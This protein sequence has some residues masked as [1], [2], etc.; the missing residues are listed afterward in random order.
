MTANVFISYRRMDSPAYAGWLYDVLADEIGASHVFRDVDAIEPGLDFHE[1]LQANV[2]KCDVFLAIIGPK[3]LAGEGGGAARLFDENDFV[4]VEIEA[5]LK[6]NIRVIP[7]LVDGAVMPS[8]KDLPDSLRPLARR[9]AVSVSHARFRTDSSVILRA[10]SKIAS[11]KQEKTAAE[12]IDR[13]RSKQEGLGALKSKVANSELF[14]SYIHM[15]FPGLLALGIVAHVSL[16]SVVKFDWMY[17]ALLPLAYLY[18][19]YIG[20]K[21][22]KAEYGAFEISLYFL[23]LCFFVSYTMAGIFET[24]KL[25]LVRCNDTGFLACFLHS[26]GQGFAFGSL[27]SAAA[28]IS[29]IGIF[30]KKLKIAAMIVYVGVLVLAAIVL[31]GEFGKNSKSSTEPLTS[32][33]MVGPHG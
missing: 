7:V 17:G 24:Y 13:S 20:R 18:L 8:E 16:Y 5:A 32:L 31:Y 29:I 14:S 6:R 33:P 27:I 30:R 28:S 19:L 12:R 11:E 26:F 1:I 15:A 4:R 10:I 22:V 25:E 9:N 2:E 3:W 21:I 23:C